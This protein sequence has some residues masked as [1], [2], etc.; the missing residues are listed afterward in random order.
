LPS[1]E[2]NSDTGVVT[3][4][5]QQKKLPN[6]VN[7][8]I[9]GHFAFGIDQSTAVELGI[10]E[11]QPIDA[12][13]RALVADADA[14]QAAYRAAINVLARRARS[15]QELRDYLS[16][17]GVEQTHIE[18]V[19]DRLRAGGYVDDRE[20]ARLWVENRQTFRPR[21]RYALHRELRAKG[22]EPSLAEDVLN[23][24]DLDERSVA[25]ELA[26][27]RMAQLAGIDG[28]AKERRLA[29][30]LQRRGFSYDTV[31]YVLDVV[32]RQSDTVESTEDP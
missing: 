8:F 4:V 17:K 24:A 19:I 3:K 13:T 10:Q 29:G 7:I 9:D 1:P 6:R 31:K 30:F 26:H 20:F 23:S 22:V 2:S 14:Q 21:G 32:G 16:R 27:R 18:V 15:E 12:A 28:Y 11:G 25:L 5:E